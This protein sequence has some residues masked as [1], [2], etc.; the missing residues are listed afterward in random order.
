MQEFSKKI[1]LAST[2]RLAVILP[3]LA[4]GGMERMR[5]HMINEWVKQGL[6]VDLVI[7]KLDGPLSELIPKNI[8]TFEVA[9]SNPFLFPLGFYHYLRTRNPT[10]I[11]SAANDINAM[12]LL[13][14]R[15]SRMRIPVVI[16]VH[17]HLGSELNLAKGFE[18]LKLQ[19]TVWMLRRLVHLSQAVI[20]VSKGVED[21]LKQQLGLS[22][23][24]SHVIYNPVITPATH[25]FM[26]ES[27]GESPVPDGTQW[28]LFVGRFVHAKGLDILLDA[29]EQMKNE[30]CAHLVLMGDGPLGQNIADRVESLGLAQRIH[31]IGFRSNPLPWMKAAD[32]LV[33]PSRHEG[34]G[35]VL[36]EALACGTKI[37][38]TDCPSGPSEILKNGKFGRLVDPENS[39]EL[40]KALLEALNDKFF[41]E[42]DLKNRAQSFTVKAATNK[43][44]DVMREVAPNLRLPNSIL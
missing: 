25:L 29:F 9:K 23:S 40:A 7:S 10:H 36:I 12:V 24:I 2:M 35:N 15:L 14:V 4:G 21:D 43:Y 3:S 8:Q 5:I 19:I 32:V 41:N 18:K 42:D 6:S 17:N 38:S 27:I 26:E 16:S 22:N 30:T 11:L 39:I 44:L 34:L 31:M 20:S 13:L 33:L 1:D 28:I 37:V